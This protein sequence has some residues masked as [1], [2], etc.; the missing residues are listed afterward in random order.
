MPFFWLFLH[1]FGLHL[2]VYVIEI[3]VSQ[4]LRFSNDSHLKCLNLGSW[5][6]LVS[7]F[8]FTL[9]ALASLP[10]LEVL[11]VG[12]VDFRSDGSVG[13]TCTRECIS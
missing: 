13:Y 5:R 2:S 1:F 11:D 9:S 3:D 4:W 7:R 6:C 12:H 8:V 10:C